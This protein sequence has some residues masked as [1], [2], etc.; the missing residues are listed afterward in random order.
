MPTPLRSA[1][2]V[3]VGSPRVV[4]RR[5]AKAVLAARS[6]ARERP[7]RGTRSRRSLRSLCLPISCRSSLTAPPSSMQLRQR[8]THR[9]NPRTHGAWRQPRPGA[10]RASRDVSPRVRG[11]PELRAR[12]NDDFLVPSFLLHLL[13]AIPVQKKSFVFSPTNKRMNKFQ[14]DSWSLL[15]ST[16]RDLLLSVDCDAETFP[17][18]PGGGPASRLLCLRAR[19]ASG[20]GPRAS[21][22]ARYAHTLTHT[23][24]RTHT[25]THAH[26][27]SRSHTCTLTH[28]HAHT[29]THSHAYTLTLMHTLT[30]TLTHAHTYTRT[31]THVRSRTCTHSHTHA[32]TCVYSPLLAIQDH[33][34]TGPPG[35]SGRH[36]RSHGR[37]AALPTEP[38]LPASST[39]TLGRAVLRVTDPQ[40]PLAQPRPRRRPPR[41]GGGLVGP[42][43]A[44]APC[45][46]P[47]PPS[48]RPPLSQRQGSNSCVLIK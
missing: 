44:P 13:V 40:T 18:R 20:W 23:L 2:H 32:H 48:P 8:R 21:S 25:L 29:Y 19:S 4:T 12:P 7:R 22:D 36:G 10:S 41:P 46:R 3:G 26:T 42:D 28:A 27:Y 6:R 16:S 38:L 35:P 43:R 47:Q 15:H 30:H 5:R 31:H 24:A 37:Q 34:S 17:D 9:R 11:A 45:P 39:H 14:Y 1:G 33:A